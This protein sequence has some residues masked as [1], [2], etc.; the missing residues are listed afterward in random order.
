MLCLVE[1]V[2]AL[3]SLVN[4]TRFPG[5]CTLGHVLTA[6]TLASS[7]PFLSQWRWPH[8]TAQVSAMALGSSQPATPSVVLNHPRTRLWAFSM[9][10]VPSFQKHRCLWKR[11]MPPSL[12]PGGRQERN[13]NSKRLPESRAGCQG[14]APPSRAAHIKVPQRASQGWWPLP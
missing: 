5:E 12:A 9:Q 8:R 7:Y 3:A 4:L 2:P 14:R 6:H 1:E 13:G 10:T 11:Q